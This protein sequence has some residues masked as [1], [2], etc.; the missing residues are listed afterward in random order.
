MCI[1]FIAYLTA[2][3]LA[4]IL[5]AI[6]S[7]F[8]GDFNLGLEVCQF[9]LQSPNLM[10]TNTMCNDYEYSLSCVLL[11]LKIKMLAIVQ[12]LAFSTTKC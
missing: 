3:D 9:W 11:E 8:G 10:Y 12:I 6:G 7:T 4:T 5:V 2:N 1:V